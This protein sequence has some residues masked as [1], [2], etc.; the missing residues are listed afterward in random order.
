MIRSKEIRDRLKE[1]DLYLL[2][3][4]KLEHPE[5]KRDS[6]KYEIL[7]MKRI[8]K[9]MKNLH[10][11]IDE[12][13]KDIKVIKKKGRHKSLNPKQKL[14]LILIK[15]LVGK[16]NRMMAYM[17]DIFSMMSRVD[18][19]YKSVERL[20]S[21][22][23]VYLTL[24]NLFALLLKKKG[25][26]KIDAC[27]DATGFSLTIKKHYASYVQKLKDK[28][29]EQDV[30]EKKSFV[31]RFNIMDLSTKM[32]VCYGS[33]LKSEREAFD[34]AMQMLEEYNLKIDSIRLDRYYSNPCYVNLFKESKVYVIP[35]KNVELGNGTPWLKTMERF[36]DDTLGYLAEYY[37]RQNSESGFSSDKKLT[38]WKVSQKREDRI[39]TALFC[40]TIW[41]NLFFLFG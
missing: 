24:S 4:Y 13:T 37:K 29:K 25:I 20:Y 6:A 26:E 14:T 5:I 30:N 10:P 33:S 16:S 2:E 23:E 12:A 34:K 32:Y 35:K 22:E 18:V 8:K 19:S 38:G 41:H 15:Q 7:F 27:G 21:D 3:K 17:I 39:N 31:Y 11:I 28:S 1:I 9:V 40:G 36:L